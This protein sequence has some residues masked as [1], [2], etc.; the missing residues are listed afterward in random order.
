VREGSG[1]RGYQAFSDLLA[2]A[3]VIGA[4]SC[5]TTT[6]P[7]SSGTCC[8]SRRSALP[9][10]CFAD[11]AAITSCDD[12]SFAKERVYYDV[13]FSFRVLHDAFGVYQ[14]LLS[15]DLAVPL[16]PRAAGGTCLGRPMAALPR[17]PE[18]FGWRQVT[19]LGTFLPN[20]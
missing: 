12:Y 3:N 11:V 18:L 20:F 13:G 16:T 15:I 1:L 17:G 5:A 7:I 10:R 2:R 14:Q 8:T 4:S 9:A 6:S 19:L